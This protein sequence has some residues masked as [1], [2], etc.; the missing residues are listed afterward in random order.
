M[1]EELGVSDEVL[2]HQVVN[3]D[4]DAFGV[5]FDRHY[6][7]VRRHA[8]KVLRI[9]HLAEDVVAMVF[10]EAW[11]RR[12]NVRMVND[13]IL[14][15]LLITTNNTLRNHVRQQR[16]YRHFLTQLP[17]PEDSAD[18]AEG[19][20]Q[21]DESQLQASALR[22]AFAQL[23]PPERDVLTLCVVEGMGAKEAGAALGIADGTVKSRLHR[24]KSRLGS[25]YNQVMHEKEP[26]AQ[27]TLGWRTS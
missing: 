22:E 1:G 25:L 2:W 16:R 3:G 10:Y 24:A 19:I 9:P 5:L 7:R 21:A 15:W 26:D 27:T 20:A 17:P 11:R 4:G 23:R 12:T 14:P 8:L 13:S 6:D 18:I